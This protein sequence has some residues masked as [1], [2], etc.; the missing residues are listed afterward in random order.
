MK[1]LGWLMIVVFALAGAAV[2]GKATRRWEMLSPIPAVTERLHEKSVEWADF[3]SEIV[4]S[5]FELKEKSRVTCKRYIS[6]TQGVGV[7]MSVTTGPPGAVATHT[8]DVCYS[9]GGYKQ[10]G[11]VRKETLDLPGGRSVTYYVADFEKQGSVKEDRQRVRWSWATPG[12][13]WNAPSQPRLNFLREP[14]LYKLY[15]VTQFPPVVGDK[16]AEDSVAQKAFVAAA[17]A[18]TADWIAQP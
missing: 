2:H 11:P 4:P 14:E 13:V 3:T 6:T 15:V 7:M 17:F 10:L 16:P 9:G 8:P 5:E 18:Q 12:K 1:S